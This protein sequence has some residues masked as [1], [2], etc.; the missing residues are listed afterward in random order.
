MKT[1]KITTMA[2]QEI[3]SIADF[4]EILDKRRIITAK[5]AIAAKNLNPRNVSMDILHISNEIMH[6]SKV[7]REIE[8]ELVQY[9]EDGQQ[10][11]PKVSGELTVV[12][13]LLTRLGADQNTLSDGIIML[14]RKGN[15]TL[16]RVYSQPN[17]LAKAKE[18][19]KL[20]TKKEEVLVFVTADVVRLFKEV[21]ATLPKMEDLDNKTINDKFQIM[22]DVIQSLQEM[23]NELLYLSPEQVRTR[24][25][26]I[27]DA[28]FKIGEYLEK[29]VLNI[30]ETSSGIVNQL[31]S[32][33]T[34]IKEQL[35]NQKKDTK[36]LAEEW[37]EEKQSLL[38]Q[39]E[40]QNEKFDELKLQLLQEKTGKGDRTEEE[41][42]RLLM[43]ELQEKV[44]NLEKAQKL[45]TDMKKASI[46]VA[47]KK[48]LD[49]D[50]VSDSQ[51]EIAI[52][53][54]S[55][56][57]ICNNE[58]KGKVNATVPSKYGMRTWNPVTSN[59]FAHLQSC[60]IGIAQAQ[61]QK[62]S[63][64][65]IMNLVLMTLPAEYQYI[66]DFM[67][68]S[69]KAS[70]DTFLAKI[71]ELIQGSKQEQLSVFLREHRKPG[72]NI[73]GYFSRI[74]ALYRHSSGKKDA[75]LENDKFGVQ[76]I[77]QKTFEGMSGGQ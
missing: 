26:P 43:A 42:Q 75:D 59:I 1:D 47:P 6:E 58:E 21:K 23:S 45:V 7:F 12:K 8:M 34:T 63:D 38:R 17:D 55:S 61:D 44:K 27:V 4:Q 72:E 37:E 22:K 15:D 20:L 30:E 69:D 49:E 35:D 31:Q 16:K 2:N 74:S 71:I 40:K 70:L 10:E 29:V 32:Q 36:V 60:K 64:S 65:Q 5:E 48:E 41:N 67:E 50:S 18:D 39:Q 62:V 46:H 13:E 33:I 68:D 54:T 9:F 77:Y 14:T 56:N 73:L 76:L 52:G 19:A 3:R 51:S 53:S 25:T 24:K 28:V 11:I 66:S 57:F